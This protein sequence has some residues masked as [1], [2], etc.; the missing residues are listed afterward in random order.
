MFV[1]SLPK[2]RGEKVEGVDT[3]TR[4]LNFG[5]RTGVAVAGRRTPQFPHTTRPRTANQML[6]SLSQFVH[7]AGGLGDGAALGAPANPSHVAIVYAFAALR[8]CWRWASCTTTVILRVTRTRRACVAYV[9]GN[10]EG[11]RVARTICTATCRANQ[12]L[13]AEADES[14]TPVLIF[15]RGNTIKLFGDIASRYM[16]PLQTLAARS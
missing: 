11:E 15:R 12:R 5:L 1:S 14:M 13:A 10:T 16:F 2:A 3:T 9:R 4:L 7:P 8:P 6:S